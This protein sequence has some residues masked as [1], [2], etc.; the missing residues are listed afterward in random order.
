[1]IR[2]SETVAHEAAAPYS[3]G[4]AMQRM[5]GSAAS[6]LLGSTGTGK[7]AIHE[8]LEGF[9]GVLGELES[10]RLRE[11]VSA[12]HYRVLHELEATSR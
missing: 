1:M 11:L 3:F 10:D 5:C 2:I 12:N 7:L 6:G 8:R 4:A 9:L